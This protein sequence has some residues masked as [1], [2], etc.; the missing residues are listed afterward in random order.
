MNIEN[1]TINDFSSPTRLDNYHLESNKY[2]FDSNNEVN[3]SLNVILQDRE[4]S[5]NLHS[6]KFHQMHYED[7]GGR[8]LV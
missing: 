7:I 1:V 4:I 8:K 3:R 6:D 5:S 2:L